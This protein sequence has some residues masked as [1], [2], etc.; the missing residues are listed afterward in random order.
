MTPSGS[1]WNGAQLY[2][3]IWNTGQHP[4]STSATIRRWVAPSSGTWTVTGV[5][6]DADAGG[7]NGVTVTI[8]QNNSSTLYTRTIL[9]GGID[10]SYSL[11]VPL[12]AGET[13]EFIVEQSLDN[14]YDS[15]KV[16]AHL[17]LDSPP[18]PGPPPPTPPPPPSLV[19]NCTV[20][21][22]PN[23][24]S[25]VSFYR[26]YWGVS[27]GV[28]GVPLAAPLAASPKATCKQLGITTAGTYYLAVAAVDHSGNEGA[29]SSEVTL[30]FAGA[31]PDVTAPSAP[32]NVSAQ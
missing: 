22:E 25:D 5:T 26:V 30:V 29:L 8:K 19:G 3:G 16:T 4:G 32:Q 10:T 13:L 1:L 11:S 7:G 14:S 2:Q 12:T 31:T 28:Y 24:E 21:W 9:N 6:G 18:P 15:T 23:G 20:S 27:S 17:T